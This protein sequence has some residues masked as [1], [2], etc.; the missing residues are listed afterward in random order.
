MRIAAAMVPGV[1]LM[2]ILSGVWPLFGDSTMHPGFVEEGQTLNKH[3]PEWIEDKNM[4]EEVAEQLEGAVERG[5]L[6][7]REA[8]RVLDNCLRA[9]VY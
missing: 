3:H 6:S 4:C 7:E 8:R 5:T 9:Y 2:L 1:A